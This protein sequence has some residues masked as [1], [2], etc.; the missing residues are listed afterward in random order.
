[1]PE[2]KERLSIQEETPGKEIKKIPKRIVVDATNDLYEK[3]NIIKAANPG[4]SS[5]KAVL[6]MAINNQAH[7]DALQLRNRIE[8]AYLNR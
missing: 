3:I 2:C 8:T 1:M 4:L 5:N 6:I 7:A